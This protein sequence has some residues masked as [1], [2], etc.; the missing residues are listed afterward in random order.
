ML[1]GSLMSD[2]DV[3]SMLSAR[4]DRIENSL[5]E[6]S[7]YLRERP[8]CPRPGLCLDLESDRREVFARITRLERW[9]A[10]MAGVGAVL[11]PLATV[12]G[13]RIAALLGL[14]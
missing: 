5:D 1:T 4:L 12:F 8:L 13:P 2:P 3:I 7:R 6:L 9:Q 10:W 14:R 11:I